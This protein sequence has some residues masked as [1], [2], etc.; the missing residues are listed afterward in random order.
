MYPLQRILPSPYFQTHIS[1]QIPFRGRI[2]RIPILRTLFFQMVWRWGGGK[3]R[4]VRPQTNQQTQCKKTTPKKKTPCYFQSHMS[5]VH[6]CGFDTNPIDISSLHWS[7]PLCGATKL[8]HHMAQQ[9][10]KKPTTNSE[11][12]PT[13]PNVTNARERKQ[14]KKKKQNQTKPKWI[15]I[16][17]DHAL[18]MP[19]G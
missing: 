10:H 3:V 7:P 16:D 2:S 1:E 17:D 15:I 18:S 19:F 6:A 9:E 11:G 12:N 8:T 4:K 5:H 13:W 14:K